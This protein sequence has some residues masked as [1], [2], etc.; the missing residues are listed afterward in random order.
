MR[1]KIT[2]FGIVAV[3]I[4]TSF[5]AKSQ[6]Y[7]YNNNYY[8]KDVVWEIGTSVGFMTGITDVGSKKGFM[9]NFKTSQVNGSFYV[10][11]LYQGLI[12]ARLEATYGKI[13]GADSLGAN[14]SRNL[15]FRTPITEIAVIG[16]FHP[17]MLKYYD[18]LPAFSPY[19]ALGLGW[20]SF[21]PQANLKGR[22]IDLQPLRTEGQGFP[23]TAQYK[24]DTHPYKLSQSNIILGAGVK[25][26]AS[27][28]ITF[29]AELLYR[30][31]FTDYLDDASTFYVDPTWFDANLSANNAALAKQ[32]YDRTPEKSSTVVNGVGSFIRGNEKT[33]DA[34][35]TFNLK[36][37]INLGRARVD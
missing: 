17:L 33:K 32:L 30:K 22:W 19:V 14:P 36:V 10:G 9:P 7:Y 26:E 37:G 13:A 23:Q 8:D 31:T 1:I 28:L 21:N 18:D 29:R 2:Q 27:Q 35:F 24:T 5:S 34:Y 4:F 25:F 16:E 15:S 12:G 20:F 11:A 6:Y 3:L